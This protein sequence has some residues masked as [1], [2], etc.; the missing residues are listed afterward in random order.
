MV[1]KKSLLIFSNKE[2]D[3][4][5]KTFLKVYAVSNFYYMVLK[6]VQSQIKI[7]ILNLDNIIA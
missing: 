3:V 4:I 5:L 2:Y 6:F 7:W 1:L